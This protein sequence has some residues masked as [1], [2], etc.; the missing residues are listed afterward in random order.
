MKG[1]LL[2]SQAGIVTHRPSTV[3]DSCRVP[4]RRPGNGNSA[5][6]AAEVPDLRIS[7]AN[8]GETKWKA[9]GNELFLMAF[10]RFRRRGRPH[11]RMLFVSRAR[12]QSGDQ[13]IAPYG[14][15]WALLSL[16]GA[17]FKHLA[18]LL[19]LS[20]NMVALALG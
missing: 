9:S 13:T 7:L 20:K 16:L 10:A 11:P 17:L 3:V 6:S 14:F 5:Q 2:A 8:R 19:K 18:R 1:Q 15:M 12:K 4:A